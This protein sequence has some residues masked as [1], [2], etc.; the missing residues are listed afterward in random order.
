VAV[1][2]EKKL[3]CEEWLKTEKKLLI[4]GKWVPAESGKTFETT[5]PATEKVLCRVAEGSKADVDKAVIAARRAFEEGPWRKMPANERARLLYK[6]AD[7]IEKRADEFAQLE[8]L[9]NG[10]PIR[11][12]RWVDVVQT[13]E[14]FRYYA[15]WCTKLE[16]ETNT[17]NS[18]FFTY[19]LREPVGVVGQIIPW[20]FPMLMAAW[21]LGPALAC[22]NCVVLKPAEQTPLTALRI[23]ELACEVGFPPGVLN[24]ITGFGPDA[25]GSAISNHMDIDKVAFTGEDKT[26]KEIV[27]ASAGNL[28][29]VSLELGGKA[30]NIVFADADI[31]A[32]VKGAMLGIFFNQGQVCCAGSRLF[33]ENK[34]HDEFLTKL[35]DHVGK[36]RQGNGLDEQTVIGPQVSKEQME[37]ILNYCN[38]AKGEGAK[39][40]CGGESPKGDLADGYFVKPTIFDGVHND[41][42]IA[43]EEVFG[44][45][46]AVLPFKTEQEVAE[47]A[48][49]IAFGLSAGIWTRDIKK[50]HKLV[51]H[52]K[53][54]TVWVN[55]YNQFDPQMPFG[56]Y[57]LSGYGRE[58]GKHSI[59]LYT[60]VK[61]V[62]VNL[63]D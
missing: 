8:T 61:S 50:A 32:A 31:D 36:M 7:E 55:C 48:N 53:A 60:T 52:L 47:Q 51:N 35:T 40:V 22:G 59:E 42:R 58:L 23:A 43:Q 49:K 3:L 33:V 54:G 25:A 29:R 38:I 21:K 57:K 6:L 10:K 62:W 13:V 1:V 39:L 28:K 41:M 26:G 11:E 27:K 15:G 56:G 24:V 20:N 19:T 30:P 4:D 63:E 44:P 34:V 12:S 16:G 46:L 17:V 2:Q 14:T 37:R 18:K 9:D 45:V 5:N